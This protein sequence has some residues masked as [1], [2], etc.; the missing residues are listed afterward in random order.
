MHRTKK[1]HTTAHTRA[2]DMELQ[3]PCRLGRPA[4]RGGGDATNQSE[5][6]LARS[7]VPRE[8]QGLKKANGELAA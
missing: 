8:G 3:F 6:A 2:W 5:R 1:R 4:Q 7:F